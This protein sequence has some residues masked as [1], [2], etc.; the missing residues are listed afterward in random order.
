MST[1]KTPAG[2]LLA[3]MATTGLASAAGELNIYNWATTPAP[4]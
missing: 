4:T 1:T 3:L 2:A